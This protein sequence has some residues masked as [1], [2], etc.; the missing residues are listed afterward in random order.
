MKLHQ[1]SISGTAEQE[2]LIKEVLEEL[3]EMATM[4]TYDP[5]PGNFEI[6]AIY[7]HERE[8]ATLKERTVVRS[9]ISAS[10]KKSSNVVSYQKYKEL[11]LKLSA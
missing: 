5:W 6:I 10:S 9:A 3:E 8:E 4:L 2:S 7:P 1:R 11:C